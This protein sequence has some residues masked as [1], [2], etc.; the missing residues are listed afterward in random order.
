MCMKF[1]LGESSSVFSK[2]MIH[3]SKMFSLCKVLGFVTVCNASFDPLFIKG[4]NRSIIRHERIHLG[5]DFTNFLMNTFFSFAEMNYL[6]KF[7]FD[8]FLK[9]KRNQFSICHKCDC[10]N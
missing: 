3:I 8:V 7:N 4:L 5:S 2:P 10:S 6:W 9:L 1:A